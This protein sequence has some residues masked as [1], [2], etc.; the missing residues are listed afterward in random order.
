M[1]MSDDC[2][3]VLKLLY[4]YKHLNRLDLKDLP[5]TDLI[6]Y[7]TWVISEITLYSIC[8]QIRWPYIK[9]W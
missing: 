9:E 2:L 4:Q 8:A 6:V 1:S 5:S 7:R 3:K